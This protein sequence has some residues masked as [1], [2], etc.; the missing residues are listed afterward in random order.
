MRDSRKGK[1]RSVYN[2]VFFLYCSLIS[3][4]Y[5]FPPLVNGVSKMKRSV[6]DN[7]L[8]QWLADEDEEEEKG[9]TDVELSVPE[10]DSFFQ[11]IGMEILDDRH[12][13][14]TQSVS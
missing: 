3:W 14:Q 1:G 9:N 5:A 7:E 4:E 10:V 13:L 11:F 12:H 6:L 8:S 2:I